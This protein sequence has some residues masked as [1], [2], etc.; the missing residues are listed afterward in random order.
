M[1]QYCIVTRIYYSRKIRYEYTSIV[2][3]IFLGLSNGQTEIDYKIVQS[4]QYNFKLLQT[5]LSLLFFNIV[6]MTRALWFHRYF[7]TSFCI[8]S[9]TRQMLINLQPYLLVCL[10]RLPLPIIQQSLNSIRAHAKC[11]LAY[12]FYIMK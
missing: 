11:N 12:I 9:L 7:N 2:S 6:T 10:K 1:S 5:N 8:S 3:R 4:H